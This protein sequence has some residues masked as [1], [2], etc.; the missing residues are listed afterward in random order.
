MDI[1]T[2][3][4]F[5]D[6]YDCPDLREYRIRMYKLALLFLCDISKRIGR[7]LSGVHQNC[8]KLVTQEWAS[9][10]EA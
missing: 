5:L 8:T 10:G 4:P 7:I 2:F 1:E 6:E 3:T 9:A